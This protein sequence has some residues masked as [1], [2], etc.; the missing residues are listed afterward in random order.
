MHV[1]S[2]LVPMAAALL[3]LPLAAL[4]A[5]TFSCSAKGGA[6]WRAVTSDHFVLYTDL[7]PSA[8]KDVVAELELVRAAVLQALFSK[9]PA[10]PGRIEV[11][12]FASLSDFEDV[13]PSQAAAYYVQ[14]GGLRPLVVMPGKLTAST[15][16]VLAHEMAHHLLAFPLARRPLWLNEGLAVYLQPLGSVSLGAGM[17]VGTVPEGIAIPNRRSKRILVKDLLEW[18]RVEP[19]WVRET[20]K[21]YYVS[22]WLLVHY[23]MNKQT[24]GFLEMFRRLGRAEDPKAAW[25]AAFPRWDPDQ[26]GSLEDLEDALDQYS[27]GEGYQ[28]HTIRV[29]PEFQVSERPLPPAEVHALRVELAPAGTTLGPKEIRAEL[30]EALSE[31]P[32]HPIAVAALAELTKTS[33]LPGARAATAAHPGDWRAWSVLGDALPAASTEEKLAARRKAAELAPEEPTALVELARDLAAAGRAREAAPVALRARQ[34]APYSR[35][36]HEAVAD[37]ALGLGLCPDAAGAE[38]RAMDV[39]GDAASAEE[40]DRMRKRLAEIESTCSGGPAA[41]TPAAPSTSASP[42]SPAVPTA[43]AAPPGRP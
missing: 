33:A 37:V 43:P 24:A 15:R 23:L 35:A 34:V 14:L 40:Q 20:T 30:D 1:R 27:R 6:P 31:D 9:P 42:A 25:K 16:E 39:L 38:K 28:Y 11:V 5:S 18:R 41:S 3:A 2:L 7:D 12:A 36:V 17:Q 22:S 8:A 21:R 13:A 29:S 4:P 10:I 32:G 26:P 19:G